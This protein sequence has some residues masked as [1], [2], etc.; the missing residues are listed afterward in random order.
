MNVLS[1]PPTRQRG[2]TLHTGLILIFA[3]ITAIAIWR[4]SVT[5][6]GPTLAIFILAAVVAFFPLP[7][8][9]YGLYALTRANYSLDRDKLSLVWGLRTEQIPIADVEW[10]RSVSSLEGGLS[11]PFVHLPGSVLGTRRHLD[12]GVVEFLASDARSL[13]LVATAKRTFAISPEDA[14]GFMENMQHVIEMGSLTPAA[15]QSVYLSF[16]V[17]Q[18]WSSLLARYLW[19]AGVFLNAGL[20]VWVS[21]MIPDLKRVPLGFL[22]SGLPRATVP[23]VGLILLPVLSILLFLAGWVAGLFFYRRKDQHALAQVVW[24]SGVFSSLLFL[25]AVMFSVTT[26]I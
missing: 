6:I 12:L 14:A 4:A 16:I 15:P 17:V 25:V 24:A 22:A 20:L 11:L 1:F 18:A 3:V 8:L 21:L 5:P 26:P 2:V 23:G 19:L 10:V 9:A 7:F 13:L